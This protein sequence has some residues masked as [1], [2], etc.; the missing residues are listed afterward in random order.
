[1]NTRA[2]QRRSS[3]RHRLITAG[4][5]DFAGTRP[6]FNQIWTAGHSGPGTP[7]R[8]VSPG[9][10]NDRTV[11]A[12]GSAQTQSVRSNT[13]MQALRMAAVTATAIRMST[14]NGTVQLPQVMV[15]L[16][17]A[18]AAGGMAMWSKIAARIGW[19]T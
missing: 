6:R 17:A 19:T 7:Q 18:R 5:A 12:P 8:F 14:G 1:M 15:G 16:N 9:L 13:A 4:G 3:P 11:S 10:T 2:P